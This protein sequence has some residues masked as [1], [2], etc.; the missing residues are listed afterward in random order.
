MALPSRNRRSSLVAA[1]VA[2]QIFDDRRPCETADP[3]T[4][5][6]QTPDRLFAIGSRPLGRAPDAPVL[7]FH[8]AT[9]LRRHRLAPAEVLQTAVDPQFGQFLLGAVLRQAAVQGRKVDAVEVLILVE[10]REHDGL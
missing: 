2:T 7:P 4:N 9:L 8:T 1:A 3:A 10:A 5:G 6:I